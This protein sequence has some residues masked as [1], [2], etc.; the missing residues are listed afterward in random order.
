MLRIYKKPRA[1]F[2]IDPCLTP[3]WTALAG[4]TMEWARMNDEHTHTASPAIRWP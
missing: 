3:L 4:T 1:V 2:C